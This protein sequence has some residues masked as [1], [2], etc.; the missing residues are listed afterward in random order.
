VTGG[1]NHHGRA[2]HLP[3]QAVPGRRGRRRSQSGAAGRAGLAGANWARA[4]AR[5]NTSAGGPSRANSGATVVDVAGAA[6]ERHPFM[7]DA[8]DGGRAS[9]SE[10]VAEDVA[11][12]RSATGDRFPVPWPFRIHPACFPGGLEQPAQVG[13]AAKVPLRSRRSPSP[14]RPQCTQLGSHAQAAGDVRHGLPV[15]L[16]GDREEQPSPATGPFGGGRVRGGEVFT[17]PTSQPGGRGPPPGL[18]GP[19]VRGHLSA[20]VPGWLGLLCAV[21]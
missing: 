17:S 7:H 5:P 9:E 13:A 19:P 1:W 4:T 8:Q 15:L 2:W 16:E 6:R 10:H 14:R 12:P 18:A 20:A 21:T 11:R 3:Q